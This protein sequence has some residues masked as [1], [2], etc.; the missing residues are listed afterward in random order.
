MKDRITSMSDEEVI[1]ELAG[2]GNMQ[3]PAAVDDHSDT[4]LVGFKPPGGSSWLRSGACAAKLPRLRRLTRRARRCPLADGVRPPR[5][6]SLAHCPGLY[7]RY[8]TKDPGH[9]LPFNDGTGGPG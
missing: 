7:A 1:A 4:I 5:Q 6:R 8:A 9:T 2:N 3:A